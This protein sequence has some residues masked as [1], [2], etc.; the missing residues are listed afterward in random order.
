MQAI[1]CQYSSWAQVF[2]KAYRCY[3]D[4]CQS[5]RVAH[6]VVHSHPT[7]AAASSVHIHVV[8]VFT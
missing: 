1:D 7:A 4:G 8:V 5:K 2:W 3:R 6:N